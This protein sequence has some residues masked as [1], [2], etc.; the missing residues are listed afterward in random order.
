MGDV[1]SDSGV[2]QHSTTGTGPPPDDLDDDVVEGVVKDIE[3]GGFLGIGEGV[4]VVVAPPLGYWWR[5]AV[6][7][8]YWGGAPPRWWCW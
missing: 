7:G 5:G 8:G 2:S 1:G 3:D 4:T 6:G